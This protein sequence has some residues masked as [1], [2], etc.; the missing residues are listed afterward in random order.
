MNTIRMN[1]RD[2]A[3]C[4]SARHIASLYH[5]GNA[6]TQNIAS[7]RGSE[8]F[9][10]EMGNSP[11]FHE[12]RRKRTDTGDGRTP[13]TRRR[14]DSI[15]VHLTGYGA[16][17]Y[18][19]FSSEIHTSYTRI[20]HLNLMADADAAD[21]G[22]LQT[23]LKCKDFKPLAFSEGQS[24]V[25]SSPTWKRE[26]GKTL[27]TPA[28][29]EEFAVFLKDCEVLYKRLSAGSSSVKGRPPAHTHGA[30]FRASDPECFV[31]TD[32]LRFFL[33][34]PARST[35]RHAFPEPAFGFFRRDTDIS[36]IEKRLLFR[37]N[38]LVVKGRFGAGKTTLLNYLAAWWQ[39]AGFADQV[40]Y[41]DYAK[42]IRTLREILS[43]VAER[44]SPSENFSGDFQ[45]VSEKAVSK[46]LREERHVLILDHAAVLPKKEQREIQEFAAGL[47]GGK[48]LVLIS[49]D[50]N[51]AQTPDQ[52]AE[53]NVYELRGLNSR[54]ASMMAKRILARHKIADDRSDADF[55][56]LLACLKGCPLALE[57]ILPLLKR[58]RSAEV[59]L[60]LKSGGA[61][62]K[63]ARGFELMLRCIEFVFRFP[64]VRDLLI[65]LAP[66]ISVINTQGIGC[67]TEKLRQQP[68]LAHLPFDLLPEMI[69]E[70][71]NEGFL[72]SQGEISAFSAMEPMFSCVLK[73][74]LY[75]PGRESVCRAVETA[76]CQYYDALGKAASR[77]IRANPVFA[78]E[79]EYLLIEPE[80]ENLTEALKISLK[81][82]LPVENLYRA[83]RNDS[84]RKR[85]C[86]FLKTSGKAILS[87]V[88]KYPP[89]ALKGRT[90]LEFVR[91]L[92]EIGRGFLLCGDGSQAQEAY[93]KALTIW[94]GN[95][96][97]PADR[98]RR[99]SA[100]LYHQ[101]GRAAQ[102][103]GHWEQAR[104][105]FLEDLKITCK[106]NDRQGM[107][108]TI[109][110]LFRLWK[111][112]KNEDIPAAIEA[113][114]A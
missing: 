95:E 70:A 30:E 93:R 89:E 26:K 67:Y 17:G 61:E 18:V 66:F 23:L 48:T 14:Y 76:F 72:G 21:A 106:Y 74:G 99:G 62:R 45:T 51:T 36:E 86:E 40:F 98:V 77:L 92:D 34:S 33:K 55:Q 60:M 111:E 58:Y 29:A 109:G 107:S 24:P 25:N 64:H 54:N 78:K 42:E 15:G 105:F 101:L 80:Y 28:N 73:A 108:V 82:C 4:L 91:I 71:G 69:R 84:D 6:E 83:L 90:G 103:Q 41:F 52:A 59:L 27:F 43:A 114:V 87:G 38:L 50:G 12:N 16:A 47:R 11:A 22:G 44:I 8:S 37:S 88:E 63:K 65:C 20:P 46:K 68:E 39:T 102:E 32:G 112:S 35:L 57:H 9:Y 85:K 19:P 79:L 97:Y 2:A 56:K 49:S 110:N 7:L 10:R 104:D 81:L 100:A 113:A 96:I 3:Y 94:L 13:R 75:A 5:D 31:P 53:G 1:D